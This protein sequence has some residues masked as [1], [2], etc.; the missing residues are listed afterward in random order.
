[1]GRQGEDNATQHANVTKG[2][3][4]EHVSNHAIHVKE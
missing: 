4:N 3:R 1:M 2:K